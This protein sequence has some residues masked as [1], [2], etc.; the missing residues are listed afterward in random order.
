MYV[1]LVCS[2]GFRIHGVRPCHPQCPVVPFGLTRYRR[3]HSARELQ[4]SHTRRCRAA[5]FERPARNGSR[6]GTGAGTRR[7]ER[8]DQI[9]NEIRFIRVIAIAGATAAI[10]RPFPRIP[11]KHRV[12]PRPVASRGVET[13]V[14]TVQYVCSIECSGMSDRT[15]IARAFATTL[16]EAR[17]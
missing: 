12:P 7:D 2:G 17:E 14:H 1:L 11:S 3:A 13:A 16:A 8:R 10:R 15:R 4:C 5:R 6:P 9:Q